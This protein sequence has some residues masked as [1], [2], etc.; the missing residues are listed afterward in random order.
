MYNAVKA[1]FDSAYTTFSRILIR[2][3]KCRHMKRDL[4]TTNGLHEEGV[5]AR[6]SRY[7]I[8]SKVGRP[9]IVINEGRK[10]VS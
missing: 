7:T 1:T 8:K 4:C 5:V 2:T 9:T 3:I 6:L 10:G